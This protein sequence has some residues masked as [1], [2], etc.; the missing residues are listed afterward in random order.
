MNILDL[1]TPCYLYD[2][3]G[4]ERNVTDLC[5]SF[6][7]HYGNFKFGYSYK[8]SY[9]EPFL[10]S[11]KRLGALAEVVSG[12]EYELAR[13]MGVANSHII[14]NGVIPNPD[15]KTQVASAGGFVHV[16]NMVELR[17]LV[18]G[19]GVRE[20]GVRVCFPIDGVHDSRFGFY[21]DGPEFCQMQDYVKEKGV[22]INVV[23]CHVSHARSAEGFQARIT[24][25]IDVAKR[26][27]A[28]AVNIGGN[29]YGRITD[30]T[31]RAQFPSYCTFEEYGRVVGGEMKKA[32]PGEEVLLLAE[33]GTP[34]VSD[35]VSIVF[36]V[37]AVKRING[38]DFIIVDG[39]VSDAGFACKF[40]SPPYR[41]FGKPGNVVEHAAVV[42]CTCIEDDY[43]V[44]DYS[45]P[46]NV[47]DKIVVDNVGAYSYNL[48]NDF[49]TAGCR[50]FYSIDEVDFTQASNL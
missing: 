29:M 42:G 1:S 27:G 45:G 46:A 18:E 38:K 32:F 49:I 28:T 21:V 22:K 41:H 26:L 8:T 43:I 44:K 36:T 31:F 23:H 40:K 39:Q 19:Y 17:Q 14:Y 47:G 6:K 13:E 33:G 12:K 5:A 16:E 34:V 24:V 48:V 25:L 10:L 9:F 11:A 4:F 2:L 15:Y 7:Q 35:V 37:I 30:E 50:R 20:L 3:D